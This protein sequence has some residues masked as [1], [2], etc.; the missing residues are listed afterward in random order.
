MSDVVKRIRAELK[1]AGEESLRASYRR[2]F[3]EEVRLYGVRTATVKA[4]ANRYFK[5]VKGLGKHK[6]FGLCEELYRSGYCEEAFV[7]SYW[8]PRL[9]GDYEP[10]DLAVFRRWIETY[11]DNW[12]ECDGFCN[13]SVGS[14]LEKYPESAAEVKGW[15]GSDNRW[16]KRAAAVS[17]IVP[18]RRGD[19]LPDVLEIADSL[20][21]DPDD[22]V[23][24]GYGWLLKEASRRHQR[25]VFEYVARNRA[26]M[27]R[28]AL[29]Y[30]IELMPE[31]MR[32]EAMRRDA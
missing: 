15:A 9:A 30:A 27:P 17:F 6:V 21:T 14:F 23:R 20:L 19:F 3:R 16:L 26:V 7:V 25:E 4:I 1:D 10:G 18:A 2:F 13:H 32:R 11:I 24:K 8:V 22:L 5:E 31:E 29:R 28:T 12:A